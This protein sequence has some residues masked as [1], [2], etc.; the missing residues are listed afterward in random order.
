M[1]TLSPRQ[2]RT[3]LVRYHN[4]DGMDALKGLEGVKAVMRRLGTIQYD[5][6]DVVGRNADLALQARVRGYR[7]DMLRRLLYQDHF[8]VDG[9]DK[10]M[11]IYLA[12]DFGAFAPQRAIHA[13]GIRRWL[14]GRGQGEGFEMIDQVLSII[15]EKG[16]CALTDIPLGASGDYNWGPR[17]PSGAA[18]EYLFRLGRLCVADKAGT[19]RRFD[20][21]ER[22]LPPD[23]LAVPDLEGDAFDDWYVLRR[24][25]CV[26]LL[27]G[28]NGPAWQGCVVSSVGR[29]SA[30]LDRLRDQ[31]RLIPCCVGDLRE[32]FYAVPEALEGMDAYPARPRARFLAPLDNLMWDRDMIEA[33]YGFRYRWEVYTP[34]NKR[35]YGYYA[36]PVLY[37]DRLVARLDAESVARAG[38]FRL[39]GWWW[40]DGVRPGKGMLAALEWE[41]RRFAEYLEVPCDEGNMDWLTRA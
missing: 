18:M 12:R 5:P 38:C 14:E 9:Y 6:L 21:A 27:W 35:Q 24:V 11:C 30:A 22:V 4:L 17:R 25:R 33:L 15:R 2:A 13:E 7:R 3:L 10:E 19:Q 20:L 1:L 16:P 36:L 32:T 31:G 37:G 23:C 29:R 39:R 41:M 28:R 8:L 40:E 34:V 26:G